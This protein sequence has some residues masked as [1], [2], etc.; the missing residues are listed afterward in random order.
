[1]MIATYDIG[2]PDVLCWSADDGLLVVGIRGAARSEQSRFWGTILALKPEAG[3]IAELLSQGDDIYLVDVI[4]E[5][6]L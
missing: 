4:P 1:L 2:E 6:A 3:S 5:N